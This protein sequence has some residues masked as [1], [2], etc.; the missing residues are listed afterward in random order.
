MLHVVN[1]DVI[2]GHLIL[3]VQ[4]ALHFEILLLEGRDGSNMEGPC[5]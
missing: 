1:M 2:G 4:K 3:H 5:A